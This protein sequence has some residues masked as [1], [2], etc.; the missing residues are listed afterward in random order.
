MVYA[1]SLV[2]LL[3]VVYYFKPSL[4]NF[5]KFNQGFT[6]CDP[7]DEDCL[8]ALQQSSGFADL[9]NNG[10]DDDEEELLE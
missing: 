1:L 6:G 7:D 9:N 8:D 4:F 2:L 5:M 10:I 3:A